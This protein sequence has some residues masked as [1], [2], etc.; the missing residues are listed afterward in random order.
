MVKGKEKYYIICTRKKIN[1]E[2]VS[3][4]ENSSFANLGCESDCAICKC[5]V[6]CVGTLF[7]CH[8]A[9]CSQFLSFYTWR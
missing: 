8:G 2:D 7:F 9:N 4:Q 3:W 5:A 1:S 6:L